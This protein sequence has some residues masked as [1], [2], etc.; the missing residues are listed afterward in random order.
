MSKLVPARQNP[1]TWWGISVITLGLAF[2][3]IAF[4]GLVTQGIILGAISFAAAWRAATA[5]MIR[6][7]DD[8]QDD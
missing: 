1:K 2:S 8:S 4:L 5:P 6:A 7:R 3:S